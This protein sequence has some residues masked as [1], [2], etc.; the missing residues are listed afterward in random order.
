MLIILA[1]ILVGIFCLFVEKYSLAIVTAVLGGLLVT[2][3]FGYM[4][5]VLENL[6]DV[7]DRLRSGDNVKPAYYVFLVLFI[8]VTLLGLF[9]QLKQINKENKDKRVKSD[10]LLV[11]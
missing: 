11:Y 2:F 6:Y 8:I 1:G 3:N 5:G 7:F 4:I 10:R 9:Y